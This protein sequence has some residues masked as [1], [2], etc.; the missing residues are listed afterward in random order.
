[1]CGIVG[2]VGKN[3]SVPLLLDGLKRLEY[4]GYDSAGIAYFDGNGVATVKKQG[5]VAV[6]ADA[7]KN[8]VGGVGIG[9]TRWA[10]HGAPT[11]LNAHPHTYKKFTVVHNGIIENFEILKKNLQGE[12]FISET[13]TEVI[14]HL[15]QRNYCGDLL[16]A[17]SSAVKELSG[18]FAL[19]VLCSDFPDTVALARRG[20][21]VLAGRGKNEFFI[22]SDAAALAGK[23]K[24]AYRLPD[25]CFALVGD[26]KISFFNRKLNPIK[27]KPF[28]VESD[29]GNGA[30][31]PDESFML[32]EIFEIPRTLSDTAKNFRS[33]KKIA[34]FAKRLAAAKKVFAVGCGT[35]FYST[36]VGKKLFEKLLGLPFE[37]EIASEFRYKN[38]LINQ[39]DIFFAVTQSGETADTIAAA[40]LAKEKG[41][42]VAVITNVKTSSITGLA[43][44]VIP[45]VSGAE[46]GV[47]AT[48]SYVGQLAV[49]M[50]L[51]G[52]TLS[53]K[54][55]PLAQKLKSDFDKLPDLA[56]KT[57]KC[58]P[59]IKDL[60]EKLK[61]S[62]GVFYIGRGMDYAVALEA[63]LKLKEI[64]YLHCEGYAAGELKHGTFAL[65]DENTLVTA[66]ITQKNVAEKTLNAVHEVKARGAKVLLVTSLEGIK[67]NAADFVLNLPDADENL[68]PVLAVIPAQLYA[69]YVSRLKGLDPDK[70]R[71]LAKSV[72]VE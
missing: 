5:R 70:P 24:N 48:K 46:I 2:Y 59:F 27:L 12:I 72:T 35:A 58:A 3:N 64:A 17:I 45:T 6:L 67:T 47:A 14:A 62:P 38:P 60:A 15:L 39:N 18:S 19:A 36:L 32:K 4:R 16:G 26:K 66:I 9:H 21:P 51:A 41:A 33:D 55:S 42:Y 10:T 68:A 61:N 7:C 37:T 23:V 43:D 52:E 40:K 50:L 31:F 34:A 22:A 8:L 25:D 1:M 54:G 30:A 65:I 56:E 44:I 49:F 71:N 11:D 13:D 20:N 57:L 28:P 69:Y 29:G 63:A 53:L